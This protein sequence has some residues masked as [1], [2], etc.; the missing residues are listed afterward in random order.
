M[1][2]IYYKD[3]NGNICLKNLNKNISVLKLN[4]TTQTE[5]EVKDIDIE[6][7]LIDV[8]LDL[9]DI[10]DEKTFQEFVKYYITNNCLPFIKNPK[11]YY[12]NKINKLYLLLNDKIFWTPK[13]INNTL[14]NDSITIIENNILK[15]NLRILNKISSLPIIIYPFENTLFR[16]EINKKFSINSNGIICNGLYKVIENNLGYYIEIYKLISLNGTELNLYDFKEPYEI[17][18]I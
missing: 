14:S 5:E 17:N 3:S 16:W 7:D 11:N 2:K 12:E 4:K 10:N 18:Y 8:E 9:N 1:S 15:M 6:E 13:I